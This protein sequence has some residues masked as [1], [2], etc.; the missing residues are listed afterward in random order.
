[1]PRTW[2]VRFRK[3]QATAANATITPTAWTVQ[4]VRTLSLRAAPLS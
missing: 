3:T 4:V 2:I 1:M